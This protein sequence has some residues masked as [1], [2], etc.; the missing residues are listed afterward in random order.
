[1]LSIGAVAERLGNTPSVCRKCYVH[2]QVIDSYIS[3]AMV[4]AFEDQGK[5]RGR[6][7]AHELRHEELDLLHL[8]EEKAKLA[9]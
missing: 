7:N 4:K 3:G 9:A 6:K 5:E 2:P 1:M 8:L